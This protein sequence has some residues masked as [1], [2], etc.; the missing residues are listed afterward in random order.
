[1]KRF[2]FISA[3]LELVV[4]A[5]LFFAPQVVPDL[6]NGLSSHMAMARMY[7]AAALG[8]GIFAF[9]VWRNFDNEAM[10]KTFLAAFL[11]FNLAVFIAL[12]SS[13]LAGVFANPGGALLHLV[14]A[15]FTGRYFFKNNLADFSRGKKILTGV[16]MVLG[17]IGTLLFLL[18]NILHQA[19]LHPDYADS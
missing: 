14:L 17:T 3:I 12:L 1:M 16:G 6:A 13:F 7:G 10:V 18:P 9:Q 8:L 11:I 5:I 15:I 4:G 2:I 19:G